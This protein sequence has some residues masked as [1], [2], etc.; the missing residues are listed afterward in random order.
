MHERDGSSRN[1][2]PSDPDY[3]R[4]GTLPSPC[5]LTGCLASRAEAPIAAP[6]RNLADPVTLRPQER[7]LPAPGQRRIPCRAAATTRARDA[8]VA[9]RRLPE[10][11]RSRGARIPLPSRTASPPGRPSAMAGRNRRPTSRFATGARLGN[12]PGVR[13]GDRTGVPSSP[14]PDHATAPPSYPAS[15]TRRHDR[16]RRPCPP[17]WLWLT[18]PMRLTGRRSWTA[19]P[20]ASRTNP[21]RGEVPTRQQTIF[22]ACASMTK[23]IRTNPF[24]MATAGEI[25]RPW[26]VRRSGCAVIQD[27]LAS[28]AACAADRDDEAAPELTGQD[29]PLP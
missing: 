22:R 13:T 19:C 14:C 3:G 29:L 8:S 7:G 9:C 6:A 24:Q 17:R 1:G 15:T 21:A 23:A 2:S 20:R 27:A 25:P 18:G 28:Q 5:R 12:R 16:S 4:G 26:Y 11:R 10:P